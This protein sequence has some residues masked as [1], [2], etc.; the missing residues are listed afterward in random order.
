MLSPPYKPIS[1][2]EYAR[3]HL[4][5]DIILFGIVEADDND[6]RNTIFNL[7]YNTYRKIESAC[8][9]R[10]EKDEV[11]FN[12]NTLMN[13]VIDKIKIMD[14]KNWEKD[15]FLETEK[16]VDSI[17]VLITHINSLQ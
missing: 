16:C 8:I 12:F 5:T 6:I 7:L 15:L 13:D 3:I 2:E 1:R 14:E 17:R 11:R 10:E 4:L 9:P